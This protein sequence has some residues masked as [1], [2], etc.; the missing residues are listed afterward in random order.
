MSLAATRHKEIAP[1]SLRLCEV[2]HHGH[3]VRDRPEHE[4]RASQ[5]DLFGVGRGGGGECA[6]G[7]AAW[8]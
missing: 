7:S 8:R 4:H 5:R 1:C 2:E 6:C 3:G